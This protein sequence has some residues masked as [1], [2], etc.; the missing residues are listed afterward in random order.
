MLT[1]SCCLVTGRMEVKVANFGVERIRSKSRVTKYPSHAQIIYNSLW[2]A[3]ELLAN[4]NLKDDRSRQK[5]DVYSFAIICHEIMFE[6]G[7]YWVG[8]YNS[9]PDVVKM[10]QVL[11]NVKFNVRDINGKHTRPHLPTNSDQWC[12]LCNITSSTSSYVINLV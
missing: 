10:E 3:P 4:P 5:C 2:E 9:T 1:S 6:Q 11:D 7:P 8:K 12:K